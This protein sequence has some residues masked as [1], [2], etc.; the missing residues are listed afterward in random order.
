ML[1]ALAAG[2]A[3]LKS[4]EARLDV[5]GNNIANANTIG[6]RSGRVNFAE[7]FSQTLSSGSAGSATRGSQ[8][9]AQIG[10]GVQVAS[11]DVSTTSGG[12]EHTGRD[13]DLAIQGD[14]FFI[15]K[16][17]GGGQLFTR[18]G[19]FDWDA[20]GFLVNPGSGLRVQGWLTGAN[21]SFGVRDAGSLADVRITTG[22]TAA[23]PSSEVTLGGNLDASAAIGTTYD[24]AATV[25]DSLGRAW[26]LQ[27]HFK[28]VAASTW[29]WAATDPTAAS[30]SYLG[31]GPAAGGSSFSPATGQLTFDT[32]GIPNTSTTDGTVSFSPD[33]ANPVD[34]TLHLGGLTQLAAA[35]GS[36]AAVTGQNGMASGVATGV[37]LDA[38][39][40]VYQLF[41]NGARQPVAQLA[42]AGFPN[43]GGLMRTGGT[44]FTA[45]AAS[46]LVQIGAPGSGAQGS[47]YTGV[48][49]QSN[50]DLSHEFTDLIVTQRAFQANTKV[51]A[52]SD[53][54]LQD[55]VNLRR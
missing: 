28:K 44:N 9:P 12:L 20:Q 7:L 13:T 31:S 41:S 17:P 34:L 24:T 8:N 38:N 49:E 32:T 15:L 11:I 48:V 25:F 21:G 1:R 27:L 45:T 35:N 33:G 5:I 23:K 52:A 47:L 4:Q 10:L 22:Q 26:N 46:G 3:G 2:I 14:G 16:D 36:T 53:E 50:V 37:S 30:T 42:L 39:G 18:A 51:I 54:V 19:H 40:I 29:D 43:P 55:L 6:F